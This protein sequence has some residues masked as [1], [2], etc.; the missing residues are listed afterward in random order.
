[1]RCTLGL[2]PGSTVKLILNT[3]KEP[4]TAAGLA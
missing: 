3:V 4:V 2:L 1:M